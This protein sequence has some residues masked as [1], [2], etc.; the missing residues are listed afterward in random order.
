M[1]IISPFHD[2][3]DTA[4]GYGVDYDTVW[5]RREKKVEHTPGPSDRSYSYNR[6]LDLKYRSHRIGFCGKI[7]GCIVVTK[8]GYG[9]DKPISKICYKV[10]EIDKFVEE[11]YKKKQIKYYY[12]E[13]ST[14]G[15]NAWRLNMGARRGAFTHYWKRVAEVHEKY[16]QFFID[17]NTPVYLD[18]VLNA[19]LKPV[20]FYRVIDPYT[21]FQEIQMF[22]GKLRSPERPIPDISDSDMLEAK[23][24]DPKWSF[25][26]EPGKKRK[27]KK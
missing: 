12:G 15:W 6:E 22:F 24:F 11:N 7:Y 19:Q 5:I 1:R 3:Y 23:G 17:N 2:Y 25:R 16:E 21:A 27:R 26:K 4:M 14:Y 9:L 8:P 18:N 10:E 13:G 20:E